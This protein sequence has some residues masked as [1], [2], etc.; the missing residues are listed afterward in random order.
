M[1]VATTAVSMVV[2]LE[3]LKVDSSVDFGAVSK[4][5]QWGLKMDV[6]GGC[7]VASKAVH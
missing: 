5:V 6:L 1:L 2:H 3:L 7:S 4:V